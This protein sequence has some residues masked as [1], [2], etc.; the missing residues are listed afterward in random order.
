MSFI[1]TINSDQFNRLF[2]INLLAEG[3]RAALRENQNTIINRLYIDTTR[4]SINSLYYH[5]VYTKVPGSTPPIYSIKIGD[6]LLQSCYKTYLLKGRVFIIGNTDQSCLYEKRRNN[7]GKIRACINPISGREAVVKR[8]ST[9]VELE[10][11]RRICEEKPE[12]LSSIWGIVSYKKKSEIR[13]K[14]FEERYTGD[15]TS[16]PNLS[17]Q[18][19]TQC[20]ISILKA[21]IYL[22]KSELNHNDIHMKNIF[23]KKEEEKIDFR[24]G[25]FEVVEHFNFES[26]CM[27]D[28]HIPPE[29]ASIRGA[30]PH[31]DIFTL[32]VTL[33]NYLIKN[34]QE[35]QTDDFA[36]DTQLAFTGI[37][38]KIVFNLRHRFF[39]FGKTLENFGVKIDESIPIK[40]DIKNYFDKLDNAITDDPQLKFLLSV[41]KEMLCA[42]PSQRITPEDAFLALTTGQK[43]AAVPSAT[44]FNP[45]TD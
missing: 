6:K 17:S 32:G 28:Y 14:I 39:K 8:V 45:E 31:K 44:Y 41:I 27:L 30:C 18:E 29:L 10:L 21:I 26:Y 23:F 34:K 40:Q 37:I 7:K 24:L 1:P 25:D 2:E 3:D 38:P 15:L 4:F 5:P 19:L 16:C 22:K 13:H 43:K 42:D 20:A 9:N 35:W 33:L 11:C 12:G 36:I